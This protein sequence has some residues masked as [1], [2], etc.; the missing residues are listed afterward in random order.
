MINSKRDLIELKNKL[1][2]KDESYGYKNIDGVIIDDLT[3]N[4]NIHSLLVKRKDS[5]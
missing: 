3:M 2:G 5:L 4:S 1:M